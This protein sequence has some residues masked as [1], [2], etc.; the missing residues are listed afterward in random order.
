MSGLASMALGDA[1]VNIMGE[2]SG[3]QRTLLQAHSMVSSF[4]TA[5]NAKMGLGLVIAIP[6]VIGG[7]MV[8]SI[9]KF[10][11][12]EIVSN[13]LA[14]AITM[15]GD[16]AETSM[17][18]LERLADAIAMKTKWDDEN[19]KSAMASA[20]ALGF[21][22]KHI[23]EASDAV[24]GLAAR[25]NIG[26]GG[27]MRM[28]VRAHAGYTQMLQRY[29]VQ[30]DQ[31]ASK[32]E[33]YQ[34][35]L[36]YG[37][38]GMAVA[39][40]EV[41]T[42][43]GAFG[44]MRKA[45]SES[46][47]SFGQI[48]AQNTA[49]TSSIKDATKSIWT[50]RESLQ[51]AGELGGWLEQTMKTLAYMWAFVATTIKLTFAG[52]ALIGQTAFW[53]VNQAIWVVVKTIQLLAFQANVVTTQ[54]WESFKYLISLL[55]TAWDNLFSW[56]KDM[57]SALWEKFKDP[58]S[59]FKKPTW[60]GLFAGATADWEKH[61]AT[62]QASIDALKKEAS[63]GWLVPFGN[64]AYLERV[65]KEYDDRLKAIDEA[66]QVGKVPGIGGAKGMQTA[67]KTT[68]SVVGL[69]DVWK[70]MQEA[71]T[72]SKYD[73]D[74]LSAANRTAAATERAAAAAEAAN[75]VVDI[76]GGYADMAFGVVEG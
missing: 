11:E 10:M 34:A 27:A 21:N 73:T 24:V 72:K 40:A 75:A 33:K 48:I 31:N 28:V 32:E 58:S 30:I 63:V 8:Y 20:A 61:K 64:V 55:H 12:A 47:E 69:T 15:V 71:A 35:V 25:L 2:A 49:M 16:R 26:L 41:N 60:E 74:M 14:S 18:K 56:M 23:E 6:T 51:A 22:T 5:A 45:I 38:E 1:Y 62:I 50:F 68:A 37:K 54:I 53:A 43:S 9:K 7:A 59:K 36:K 19:V 70:K 66:G 46:A 65:L 29:G 52:I 39:E 76:S 67:E 17:P 44:Q 57:V 42:L 3:L 4:V 13:Q